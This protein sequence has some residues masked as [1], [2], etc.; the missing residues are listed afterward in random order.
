MDDEE[1][2][3]NEEEM[4]HSELKDISTAIIESVSSPTHPS[5][6]LGIADAIAEVL[7]KWRWEAPG[8]IQRVTKGNEDGACQREET[9]QVEEKHRMQNGLQ[10][11][12]RS[13]VLRVE[14]VGTP[15]VG[16]GSEQGKGGDIDGCRADRLDPSS[17]PAP[18]SLAPLAETRTQHY[19]DKAS[20]EICA[21]VEPF[22]DIQNLTEAQ[23]ITEKQEIP[24][25]GTRRNQL[26]GEDNSSDNMKR[27]PP[28]G[29]ASSSWTPSPAEPPPQPLHA[30][31]TLH[32]SRIRRPLSSRGAP[33]LP[34]VRTTEPLTR[35]SV[36]DPA[37]VEAPRRLPLGRE[38]C[39]RSVS[40]LV[41]FTKGT[42]KKSNSGPELVDTRRRLDELLARQD[43]YLLS[44][45]PA[46]SGSTSNPGPHLGVGSSSPR[47][48][49]TVAG[50]ELLE[51]K[52]AWRHR[53]EIPK[54]PDAGCTH[55]PHSKQNISR[56]SREPL[57][58]AHHLPDSDAAHRKRAPATLEEPTSHPTEQEDPVPTTPYRPPY[59]LALRDQWIRQGR[60][61]PEVF[62]DDDSSDDNPPNPAKQKPRENPDGKTIKP[63][64]PEIVFLAQKQRKRYPREEPPRQTQSRPYG[65]NRLSRGGVG[66]HTQYPMEI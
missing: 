17:P 30:T 33:F 36:M 43:E 53:E 49:G 58:Y 14:G 52:P 63:V 57:S 37:E 39:A 11:A 18:Q 55:C 50:G 44:I 40:L 45:N 38:S 25:E 35:N 41:P 32:R 47:R 5:T 51:P 56:T 19:I 34:S 12:E 48:P 65:E 10:F 23:H 8:L 64:I 9:Q 59:A 29:P 3:D 16:E 22:R 15:Q 46:T 54:F 27:S 20:E 26:Q 66:P 61:F 60:T 7:K 1:S 24:A 62:Q 13:S 21:P 6:G 42:G 2:G 28:V 4:L 31:Q